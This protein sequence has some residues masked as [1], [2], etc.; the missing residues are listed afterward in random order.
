VI[1]VVLLLGLI[2]FLGGRFEVPIPVITAEAVVMTVG[3][4]ISGATSNENDGLWPIGSLLVM[5]GTLAG[6]SLVGWIGW[7]VAQRSKPRRV[8]TPPP[9]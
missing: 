6:T 5:V 2:A 1:S 9:G 7:A 4:S 3:F 8:W